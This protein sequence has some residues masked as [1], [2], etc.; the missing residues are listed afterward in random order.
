[1][2]DSDDALGTVRMLSHAL[3]QYG[4]GTCYLS[5]TWSAFENLNVDLV[6]PNADNEYIILSFG[7]VDAVVAVVRAVVQQAGNPDVRLYQKQPH[8]AEH[9]Y[10]RIGLVRS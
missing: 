4:L 6:H 10:R 2:T 8:N 7:T 3:F 5:G 9:P 1:M